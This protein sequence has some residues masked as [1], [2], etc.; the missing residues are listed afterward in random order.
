MSAFSAG[1]ITEAGRV[2]LS[3]TLAG[4]GLI[5]TKMELSDNA[6]NKLSMNISRVL[7]Q[8]YLIVEA[9]AYSED[10]DEGFWVVNLNLFAKNKA[11]DEE[12]LFMA[13]IDKNPDY[14]P[15]RNEEA[16]ATITYAM[17]VAIENTDKITLV[18]T[19]NGVVNMDMLND[20]LL[21]KELPFKFIVNDNGDV[22]IERNN[23]KI[24]IPNYVKEVTNGG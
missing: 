22:V 6:G 8:D 7:Q 1:K 17:Q 12:V 24:G 13:A 18:R 3:K 21:S 10:V 11:K 16:V 2:L 4:S 23:E 9:T 14:M 19:E 15:G 5:F 20:I